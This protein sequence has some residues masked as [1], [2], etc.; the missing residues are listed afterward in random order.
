MTLNKKFLIYTLILSL[1]PCYFWATDYV[2]TLRDSIGRFGE[3][4]ALILLTLTGSPPYAIGTS[5]LLAALAVWWMRKDLDW[6]VVLL[7][8]AV[9]LGGTQAIK[10][11]MKNTFR[12]P[13]PFVV[14]M[15]ETGYLQSFQLTPD[16]FY[17]L[18]KSQRAEIIAESGA[19][20]T[21]TFAVS[22]YQATELGY[23]FPSGH[24]IFAVSWLLVFVGLLHGRRTW[25]ARGFLAVLT[26]WAMVV[27]YSRV[28][29]GM[30]YPIDLLVAT[31]LAWGWHLFLFNNLLPKLKRKF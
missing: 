13:R 30:H 14:Q 15:G 17:A 26:L 11:A 1:L 22:S 29:L 19:G 6:R 27:L 18:P 23:S 8:C 12:E 4:G 9:S 20:L 25:K 24:T 10:S 2:W 28:R 31:W 16:M 7:L 21:D 3:N 5:V